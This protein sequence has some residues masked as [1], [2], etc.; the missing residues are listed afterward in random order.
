MYRAIQNG[1]YFHLYLI[2]NN[3]FIYNNFFF[4]YD[5]LILLF[6]A[7]KYPKN[8]ERQ[9]Y[10]EVQTLNLCFHRNIFIYEY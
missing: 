7:E 6:P 4:F 3:H 8:V 2:Y 10:I 5:N 1:G 9:I